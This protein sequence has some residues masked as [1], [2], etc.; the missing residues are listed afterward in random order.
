[1]LYEPG[2]LGA[3]DPLRVI[4]P[5]LT[6]GFEALAAGTSG[7]V[8]G[9]RVNL[10]AH[11]STL[12]GE[13]AHSPAASLDGPLARAA[14][15]H[16]AQLGAGGLAVLNVV[17][18]AADLSDELNFVAAHFPAE[19]ERPPLPDLPTGAPPLFHEIGTPPAP[20]A[21]P[22]SGGGGAGGGGGGSTGGDSGGGGG[23][24][25]RAR[26]L[27]ELYMQQNPSERPRIERFLSDNA[28]D[29]HRAPSALNLPGWSEFVAR[30]S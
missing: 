28:G 6:Y 11:Q 20:P 23:G 18:G 19:N 2:P 29:H 8:E 5:R 17:Q 10:A 9:A 3:V 7:Q 26:E 4:P 12:A 30:N 16:Q 22:S 24:G 13:L 27:L 21:P 25:D 15:E 14:G 1:M